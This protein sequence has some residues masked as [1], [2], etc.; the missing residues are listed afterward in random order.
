MEIKEKDYNLTDGFAYIIFV[1]DGTE[2]TIQACLKERAECSDQ[3]KRYNMLNNN[4][5]IF[6][7]AI[8][9]FDD[10]MDSGIC[11]DANE[12]AFKKFGP[13]FCYSLFKKEARKIGI[14]FE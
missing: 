6:K 4:E 1:S 9:K 14:R 10:G 11:G 3:E 5:N 13:E 12:K 7:K 2:Y 8:S